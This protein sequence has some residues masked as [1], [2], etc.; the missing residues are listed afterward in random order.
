MVDMMPSRCVGNITTTTTTYKSRITITTAWHVLLIIIRCTIS[1]MKCVRYFWEAVSIFTSIR[2]TVSNAR[3]SISRHQWKFAMR[4]AK[5]RFIELDGR[6]RCHE[7]LWVNHYRCK[8]I[9]EYVTKC[10]RGWPDDLAKELGRN[11]IDNVYQSF[12]SCNKRTIEKIN[13][14]NKL[15]KELTNNNGKKWNRNKYIL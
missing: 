2:V 7:F 9:E 13:I 1:T 15:L 4:A 12:F 14:A 6:R 10:Y 5:D 11:P 8:T 3:T